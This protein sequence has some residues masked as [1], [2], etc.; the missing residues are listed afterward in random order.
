MYRKIYT[1]LTSKPAIEGAGFH[2]KYR[3]SIFINE[4]SILRG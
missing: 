2:M 1:I 4:N 3:N